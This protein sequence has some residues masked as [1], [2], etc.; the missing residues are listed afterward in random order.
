M[1]NRAGIT[2][3]PL[4]MESAKAKEVLLDIPC[5]LAPLSVTEKL[6]TVTS[7]LKKVSNKYILHVILSQSSELTNEMPAVIF[8]K[9]KNCPQIA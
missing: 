5:F 9:C 7:C 2:I 6:T 8:M 4:A 1:A 3:V